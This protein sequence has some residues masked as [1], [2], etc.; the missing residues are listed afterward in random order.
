MTSLWQTPAIV[1]AFLTWLSAPASSLGE[2]AQREAL[3]RLLM[4]PAA[5][6]LTNLGQPA[7]A[8]EPI[9]EAS[10]APAQEAAPPAQPGAAAGTGDQPDKAAATGAAGAKT[11]D[12]TD[13]KPKNDEK[14]WRE[15]MTN[16]RNALDRN[17]FMAEAMQSRI[18]A[19][20]TDAVNRDDP[21]QQAQVRQQLGKAMSELDRLKKQVEADRKTIAD[22]QTDARKQGVPPGWIR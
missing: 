18:N 22:I 10:A 8:M 19:L 16:A 9:P 7:G 1:V 13:E 5:A 11:D 6:S 21:A 2:A 15:R 20:Q 14:A 3:R 17:Q 4:R 12:K